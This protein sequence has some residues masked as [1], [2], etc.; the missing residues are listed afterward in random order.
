MAKSLVVYRAV[1]KG[2][3]KSYIGITNNLE[4]GIETKKIP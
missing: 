2:T 1:L 4:N 3:N